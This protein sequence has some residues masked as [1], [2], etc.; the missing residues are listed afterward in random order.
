VTVPSLGTSLTSWQ[1]VPAASR[2]LLDFTGGSDTIQHLVW[3]ALAA[4]GIAW[5]A[6]RADTLRWLGLV[7]LGF[8]ALDHANY[9][10]RA[11][12]SS[13]VDGWPSDLVAWVGGRLSWLVVPALLA[14]VVVDRLLQARTR[15]AHPGIL[16]PQETPDGLNPAPVWRI[17]TAGMPWSTWVTWQL[18]LSRRAAVTALAA[19]V[20]PTHVDSVRS[21]VHELARPTTR[22]QW[23]QAAV[24]VRSAVNPR[25]LRA[26]L[27]G[28]RMAV[29]LAALM[30]SVA[31][32]VL[33][34]FPFTSGLQRLMTGTV[35]LW[36]MV[37]ALVAGLLLT[38]AQLP[39]MWTRLRQVGD[40]CLHEQRLRP[41][42]RLATAIGSSGVG[43]ACLLLALVT[44]DARTPLVSRY[45]ALDAISD[46]LLITGLALLVLSFLMFPPSCSTRRPGTLVVVAAAAASR[47]AS[48]TTP[49]AR[50]PTGPASPT[51]RG[52]RAGGRRGCGG[53][54]SR[55]RF[56]R[57]GTT[58]TAGPMSRSRRSREAGST[59]GTSST[60]VAGEPDDVDRRERG[61]AYGLGAGAGHPRR[62]RRRCAAGPAAR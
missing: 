45:H 35:G 19:G 3:S 56:H 1:P 11:T 37:A 46:A 29:W 6:R 61:G 22:Q 38:V 55:P 44:Q 25:R 49:P 58:S 14:A 5:L 52:R 60:R 34:G 15:R 59:S 16:L 4:L 41:G 9:N 54:A 27:L 13:G 62:G 7:P 33:G 47:H 18:V 39:A 20:S 10:A 8:V 51:S 57:C 23:R 43:T 21:V 50:A 32:L 24:R 26:G 36:L 42:A 53:A 17:A 28:W 2:E 30:P 48:P 12:P 31:Y 40:P